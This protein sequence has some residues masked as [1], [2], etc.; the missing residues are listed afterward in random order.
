MSQRT[1]KQ[2]VNDLSNRQLT[3]QQGADRIGDWH[4]N[5]CLPGSGLKH[6]GSEGAFGNASPVGQQFRRRMAFAQRSEEHTSELQSLMRNSYAVF[7][8]KKKRTPPKPQ[9]YNNETSPNI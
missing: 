6:W 9:L 1:G 2:C 8:S 7:C 5:T 3:C 4:V